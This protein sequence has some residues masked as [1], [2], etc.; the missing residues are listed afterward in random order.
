MRENSPRVVTAS[1]VELVLIHLRLNGSSDGIRVKR[2]LIERFKGYRLVCS[3]MKLACNEASYFKFSETV[4]G[5]AR[6]LKLL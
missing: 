2:L 1:I 5:N 3:N 6:Q 4:F